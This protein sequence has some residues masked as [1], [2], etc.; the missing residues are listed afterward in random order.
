MPD[1]FHNGVYEV[2]AYYSYSLYDYVSGQFATINSSVTAYFEID[3]LTIRNVNVG[4]AAIDYIFWDP[5]TMT[6]ALPINFT[7]TD[8]QNGIA[9]VR[10][11]IYRI[12]QTLVNDVEFPISRPWPGA[13]PVVWNGK[14]ELG[15]VMPKGIYLF[16]VEAARETPQGSAVYATD[17]YRS[18]Y[19]QSSWLR[20]AQISLEFRNYN[21][22]T[23]TVTVKVGYALTEL[24]GVQ[25]SSAW[26]EVRDPDLWLVTSQ[27]GGTVVNDPNANPL[28]WMW[29]YL[30]ITVPMNRGGVYTFLVSAVDNEVTR[31]K[32]HRRRPALQNGWLVC[33]PE[34]HNY[35][36]SGNTG[37]DPAA[38]IAVSYQKKLPD[39]SWYVAE[40]FEDATPAA[41]MNRVNEA[42]IICIFGHASP[43]S[44]ALGGGNLDAKKVGNNVAIQGNDL[45][46]VKFAGFIGCETALTDPVFGNLLDEAFA[47]GA[48]TAL[49]FTE[50]IGIGYQGQPTNGAG[51]PWSVWSGEFWSAALGWRDVDPADGQWD[52]PKTVWVAC[53]EAAYR[54]DQKWGGDMGGWH[55]YSFRGDSNL[56]L[57]PASCE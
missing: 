13:I 26:M 40:E 33:I 25:A 38:D 11:A 45:S 9:W 36:S 41:A 1:S 51:Q 42:T 43:G 29:N 7:L 30:E 49:G 12:D 34:A 19:W 2:T 15:N 46:S 53:R 35:D 32:E 17:K 47:A 31:D 6:Q 21:P 22:T 20:V 39:G 57:A 27:A 16:T 52:A 4:G 54:I 55:S 56:V 14:D 24:F 10:V 37:S 3:N 48:T 44:I 18:G 8:S 23:G 5:A 50:K 28:T